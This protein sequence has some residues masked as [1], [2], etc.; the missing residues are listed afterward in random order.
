MEIQG[1][2]RRCVLTVEVDFL[3]WTDLA[4]P[5]PKRAQNVGSKIISLVSVEAEV[6]AHNKVK[7]QQKVEKNYDQLGNLTII[8]VAAA[9]VKPQNI[10]MQSITR[11]TSTNIFSNKRTA[12]KDDN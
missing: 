5:R 11:K 6:A 12:R 7:N 3:T 9:I 1:K 8:P 4:Q 2:A 10:V